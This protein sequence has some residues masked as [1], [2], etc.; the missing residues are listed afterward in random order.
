MTPEEQRAAEVRRSADRIARQIIDMTRN[1]LFVTLRFMDVALCQFDYINA[2]RLISQGLKVSTFA[3]TGQHM[4]YNPQYL[5]QQYMKDKQVISRDYLHMVLHCVFRHPFVSKH[6]NREYWNLACDIAVESIISE[7]DVKQAGTRNMEEINGEIQRIRSM[8]KQQITAER[9]YA[10]LLAGG[11]QHKDMEKW[12]IL[13]HH[14]EHQVWW[15]IA[16]QIEEEMKRREKEN[17]EEYA[18]EDEHERSDS[19]EDD[20]ED[21]E[22]SEED[23]EEDSQE[24]DENPEESGEEDSE[25]SQEEDTPPDEAEGDGDEADA[26]EDEEESSEEGEADA[27]EGGEEG[28][29]APEEADEED[30]EDQW[31]E[32]TYEEEFTSEPGDNG[33]SA[34][35]D[36]MADPDSDT[37]ES[38]DDSDG[39][40]SGGGSAGDDPETSEEEGADRGQQGADGMDSQSGDGGQPGDEQQQSDSRMSG[41]ADEGR[42]DNSADD[43]PFGDNEGGNTADMSGNG[44]TSRQQNQ[45]QSGQHTA[46]TGGGGDGTQSAWEH[47]SGESTQ[48]GDGGDNGSRAQMEGTAGAPEVSGADDQKKQEAQAEQGTGEYDEEDEK[49]PSYAHSGDEQRELEEKW[50]EISERMLVDLETASK[51]WGDKSDGMVQGIKK[52]NRD[53]YDYAT[54]LRKFSTL[55]EDIQINDDEFD[56][57]YYTLGM[58]RYGNIPLIEPLEY[59]EVRKVRD[60]VIAIDTSGS[61]AGEVVQ[62]FLD[63]TFSIFMQQENFFRKINLHIIQCDA[64][65]QE[66]AK[67]T[68][69]TEF[70]DYIRNLEFKGF[71][72]TDFRPVFAYVEEMMERGEFE[73]LK[74]M[75]YFTD[76]NGTYPK[77]RP[78]YETAFIFV[79]DD[80]F[81]YQVPSWAM[82]LVLETS[83]ITEEVLI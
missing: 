41:T 67:I 50:K 11:P 30:D 62:K 34:D 23:R 47:S 35:S 72:G 25:E 75:I 18:Q 6:L 12:R 69:K 7:L 44:G 32:D 40:G 16:E 33:N 20:G 10:W 59:K 27:E 4:I 78:P 66:V 61:C 17:Q 76:G 14:D 52:I 80:E 77:R 19:E 74:G 43:N 29:E 46:G 26:P 73:D 57:V 38:G 37:G 82:K 28:D 42:P 15:D 36:D 71:G 45:Q 56:Y 9:V 83:D 48:R 70:E 58:E 5:I 8:L 13:F 79:D 1:G 63:K 31:R 3:T 2:D 51:E 22:E 54:F 55:R 81:E 64:Q 65:I 24:G 39:D 68:N 49:A 21:P 60:F 53:K